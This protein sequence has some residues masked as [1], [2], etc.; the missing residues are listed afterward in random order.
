MHF[1]S[2]QKR[3]F[4][5]ASVVCFVAALT[6]GTAQA[7][8]LNVPSQYATIQAAIDAAVAGD[9]VVVAD[10]TY[11]GPG[12]K[13]LDFGAGGK[14]ITV[15]SESGNA[16]TCIIDCLG[17][18]RGFHFH[19][20]E[21]SAAV[22][23]GFT[24]RNGYVNGSSPG[25][26]SGG[27]VYCSSSNP[28]LTNCILSGNKAS[29]GGGVYCS[30][31]SPTI[32][33]CIITGNTANS[34]AGGGICC[35]NRSKPTL[36]DCTINGNTSSSGAGG[37]GIYL[38]QSGPILT[39]CIISGNATTGSSAYGGGMSCYQPLH[40]MLIDCTIK[41]NTAPSGGG[42][43][44]TG[45]MEGLELT[46][47]NIIANTALYA[48][49]GMY[50]K[51]SSWS[52]FNC[53][54]SRNV[55]NYGGGLY[56]VY[57]QYS[58]E[59]DLTNCTIS[60]NIARSGSGG[61]VY[62]NGYNP[63]LTN[64]ILWGDTTQ[65]VYPTN[66]S[67]TLRYCDVQGGWTG[68]GTNNINVDPGF[69]FAD[70]FHLMPSSPCIDAGTNN[71]PYGVPTPDPD[72]NPRPR[73]G[74]GDGQVVADMGAYEF[75]PASPS[76]A[77]SPSMFE[78]FAYAGNPD[79]IERTLS[80][81]NASGGLL[82]W[83][84]TTDCSWLS[85]DPSSGSSAGG[86]DLIT[87]LLDTSGLAI[88][89]YSCG[90]TVSALQASNT[91]RSIPL[92]LHLGSARRVPA[93]YGTIQAAIIATAKYDW[94][95]VSD[96]V[97][98]GGLD[99]GGR[100][101][102]VASMNGP[103]NCVINCQNS[104]RGFYF[105]SGEPAAARVQGFT[106]RGPNS[107]GV[108]CTSSSC[109]T[110]SNCIITGNTNGGGVYCTLSSCPTLSN[111]I[112]TGN[113]SGS[114]GGGVYCSSSASPTLTS[115][116]ISSNKTSGQGGGVY[117]YSACSPLL[118]NCGITRN[119]ASSGAGV[120]CSS[121]SLVLLNCTLGGNAASSSGG[122]VYY[123]TS[124]SSN[125]K[126][127]NCILWGDTPQ[128]LYPTS[129]PASLTCCDVQGGYSGPGNINADPLFV[130]PDGPDNDPNTWQDNDYRL[131]SG[132]PC[133]DAGKNAAVPSGVVTDLDGHPRFVDDPAIPDCQ[134]APG[135]CGTPPIVDMGAYEYQPPFVL[136]DLN[137]DGIVDVTDIA[138][139]ALALTNPAAY[140]LQYPG[141]SPSR[142]DIN[143]SGN[144]NGRDIQPFI[145]LLV[146]GSP[147]ES[148]DVQV[149]VAVLLGLATDPAH[150]AAA[151]M[152][153]SGTADG[154]DI[155]LFIDAL[156]SR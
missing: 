93:D 63:Q 111:C 58:W 39:N 122:G 19:N 90:L 112:I 23:S 15:R 16:T 76:I 17:S 24:I 107:T 149:F 22:V 140:Q 1:N 42:V 3:L 40:P 12:N 14:A 20:S 97:W 61:G 146:G 35:S 18:G 144:I 118:I 147:P 89:D 70:D 38:S 9:E 77:L 80:I 95:L 60:G 55:A 11:A 27:G 56:Y 69:A 103:A 66:G 135:T 32:S 96:G 88:G 154:A 132:S 47:C 53:T 68:P 29:S 7:A 145:E 36:T 117:C 87:L 141:C 85:A 25:G 50:C 8:T 21:T 26:A 138:P 151:D 83:Q 155:L 156:L 101:I 41:G 152:D 31:A 34:G 136:G 123:N 102:T 125:P 71:P 44:C 57:E 45:L 84:I 65:E 5:F 13:D 153:G 49:G 148:L 46:N 6:G 48:G 104:G 59:T 98:A 150:I 124:A 2:L 81:R 67:A 4:G 64:C 73:D 114:G 127:Y 72:G 126:L 142:A 74:N 128:E 91:P 115:C 131:L 129:G 79:V 100:I 30:A 86:V 99:F 75:N 33:S 108:Y 78:V 121:S 92:T 37:G 133:V 28:T 51:D 105:H 109:P 62:S 130:D 113:T 52:A 143:L 82:S 137:C 110:L 94:V 139:F 106:I 116:M 10:G 54:I 120:Y 134:Y 43:S 119:A